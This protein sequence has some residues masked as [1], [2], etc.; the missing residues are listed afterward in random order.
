VAVA[1]ALPWLTLALV[2]ALAAA[3][4]AGAQEWPQRPVRI[5]DP[6]A[7]GGSSDVSARIVAQHFTD[8]FGQQFVVENRPGA[9]GA[10]AAETVARAPADG[11]TLLMATTGQ[12]AIGPVLAKVAYDPVR[13]FIPVSAIGT[14]PFVLVVHPGVPANTV[15]EFVDYV[16]RH[17][18]QITYASSG[19]GSVGYLSMLLFL[20]RAGLDMIP[21]S[22][23]GGVAPVTDVIAGHVHAYFGNVSALAPHATS[24]MLKLLAVSSLQRSARIPQVPTLDESGLPGFKT[25]NW[26]GLMAPAGTPPAIVDRIA[27]E[28]AHAVKVPKTIELLASN[29]IEPLGNSPDEFAA[30]VAEDISFWGQVIKKTGVQEPR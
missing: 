23:K 18:R 30:L 21:V 29:G 22:Y 28:A 25:I 4:P 16:R 11:Y 7:A 3:R 8:I 2:A 15:G 5:I 6:F 20:K 26:S 19:V 10:L 1:K 9:G 12:I 27:K 13:D 17:P 24:G 14:N